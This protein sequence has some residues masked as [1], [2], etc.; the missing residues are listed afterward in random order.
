MKE[1]LPEVHPTEPTTYKY[2][3]R[4]WFVSVC[5]T[6]KAWANGDWRVGTVVKRTGSS[7]RGPAFDSKHSQGV[8]TMLLYFQPQRLHCSLLASVGSRQAYRIICI[9]G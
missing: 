3:H 1:G 8:I 9:Y 7:S 2:H 6:V 5:I 4:H